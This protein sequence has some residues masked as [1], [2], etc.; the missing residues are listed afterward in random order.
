MVRSKKAEDKPR[1]GATLSIDVD[2]FVR[3]RDSVRHPSPLHSS[4]DAFLGASTRPHWHLEAWRNSEPP[5]ARHHSTPICPHALMRVSMAF[6][7][8]CDHIA[9]AIM[10]I[11]LVVVL[12]TSTR[13]HCLLRGPRVS[14]TETRGLSS[15]TQHSS[16]GIITNAAQGR[17][18][19]RDSARR[20][21]TAL[22]CLHKA[23]QC[24]PW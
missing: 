3:T 19:T 12:N 11:D 15:I 9:S 18:R 22:E 20:H 14:T 2:S 17:H 24:S 21:S 10:A 1:E 23:Y 4:H 6:E 16:F 7:C 8:R 5:P 13:L